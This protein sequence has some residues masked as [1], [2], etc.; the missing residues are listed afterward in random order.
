MKN[1]RRLEWILPGHG[2]KIRG[3]D[4]EMARTNTRV[5]G[6]LPLLAVVVGSIVGAGIF[7]APA[8]LGR[9]ANPGWIA[10]AWAITGIGMFSLAKIFQYLALR[11]P[12]LEGGIYSY[13][14][15]VAGE[16]T[17]FNSAYG[18]WWSALFTNLA[19][20]FAI[21]KVLGLYLPSLARDKW[22]AFALATVLLWGYALLIRAG[23]RT[24]GAANLVIT[25]LKLL[26]LVFVALL[27]AFLFQPALVGDPFSEI[28]RGTGEA[29]GFWQQLGG[30]FGVMVFAF[31]GIEG[32][33]TISGKAR[34]ARDVGRVG[35]IGF[36]ITL[37]LYV[38]VSTLTLGVAPAS[39]IVNAPSPLGAVLGSAMG[40]FGRH[41]LNIGFL[42]SV[43]GALLAWLL[44]TAEV[45]YSAAVRDGAFPRAFART[46]AGATP[47]FSLGVTAA[48]TQL[49]LVLLFLFARSPD[50]AAG[51]NAPLLQNLYFGAIS[52][53]VICGL[54][55]YALSA[56]LGALQARRD[57]IAAPLVYAALSSVLFAWMFAAMA[58][59]TAAAV[60][61]YA[62]G[63]G[64]RLR[65]HRER[66]QSMPK[67]E[68]AFYAVML[69]AGAAVLY[70]VATGRI[71]F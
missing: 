5:L 35:L 28:L 71:R 2:Q 69:V 9:V 3:A 13:A 17:G 44:L 6:F 1:L 14:R 41:L 18:Y 60:V 50:I 26:P 51:G 61:V 56:L 65:V 33:V 37:I 19:F 7:N 48:V 49:L 46:N 54:V 43:L 42:F 45:P 63:L 29:A 32:G 31:M 4:G 39:E 34:R 68:A 59:Y 57:G 62:S 20:F 64:L 15:E 11:R 66:R 47:V 21:V 10:V 53:S 52:I 67:G 22:A 12:E 25:L 24:A 38:S 30:S 16:F 58:K 36:L 55:P 8:D 40:G 23:I 70:F 27:S